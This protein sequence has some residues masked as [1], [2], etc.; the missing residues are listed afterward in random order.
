[1][2]TVLCIK[3]GTRYGP[4]YVNRIYAMVARNITPPFQ[5]VCFTDDAQGIRQ[6]VRCFDLPE[7]GCP[8]PTAH[9]CTG[10]MAEGST[11]EQG[12]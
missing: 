6:E 12:A 9:Q 8:P 3:W 11:L 2:K 4:D 7:L 5:I 1:M 10:E